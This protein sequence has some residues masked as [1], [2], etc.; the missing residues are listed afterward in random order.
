MKLEITDSSILG[1]FEKAS[2]LEWLE[3]N[4]MG[5]YSST[6]ISGANTRRY[7]GLFVPAHHPPVGR[8]VMLS[9]LEETVVTDSSKILLTSSTFP[10]YTYSKGLEYFNKF[11]KEIFPTF[12]YQVGNIEIKK[13]IGMIHEESVLA[14]TYEVLQADQDFQLELKPFIA[15]R[16]F[17]SLSKANSN[18]NTEALFGNDTLTINPYSGQEPLHI[19]VKNASFRFKPEWCMSFEYRVEQQRGLD[20]HED[21]Y[22]Y[23]NFVCNLKSGDKL[24]VVVSINDSYEKMLL[25]C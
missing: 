7:H 4:G 19:F 13:T 16:D 14:I 9:K 5:G 11:V 10:N 23:G 6:T 21:L 17:H 3:T 18:L 1:D 15:F 8:R 22:Q 2:Q 24:S 20:F 12:Y 25:N